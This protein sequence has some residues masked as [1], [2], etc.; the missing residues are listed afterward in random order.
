MGLFDTLRYKKDLERLEKSAREEPSTENFLSLIKK[1]IS[2][3]DQDN[4]LR[5]AKQAVDQF[6]DADDVFEIY[7][8]LRRQQAQEEIETLKKNLKQRP[9]PS[10][11]AQLA[12]IYKDLRE[13][14]TAMKYCRQSIETFPNDDRSYCILGELRLRRFYSDFLRKDAQLAITHLEKAYELNIRNYRSLIALSKIYLQIG[15]VQKARQRLKSILLFAPEDENVKKLLD[16]SANVP[17]PPHE[18]VDALLHQVES[19]RRLHYSLD[20]ENA[21]VALSILSHE[22]FQEALESIK[23]AEGL[24]SLLICDEDGNLIAR[25]AKENIDAH[26]YF[27]VTVAI[28]Q[29]VQDSSRQMDVGR[30]QKAELEGPFGNIHI[31][32]SDGVVYMAVGEFSVKSEILRKHLQQLLKAVSINAA[33]NTT[34]NR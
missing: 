22:I 13:D 19:Q 31:V 5:V 14:E 23:G 2:L 33:K 1:Y 21:P 10:A 26:T 16:I 17:K 25:Y 7:C 4:A 28:Y 6:A 8:K 11:F 18:D 24:L 32:S 20:R 34:K 12:E 3:G 27:E 15:M 29:T 9:T 30:F